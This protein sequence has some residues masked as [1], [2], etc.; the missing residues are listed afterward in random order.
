MAV[1][2]AGSDPDDWRVIQVADVPGGVVSAS[3][4]AAWIERGRQWGGVQHQLALPLP[5]TRYRRRAFVVG[6]PDP[7]TTAEVDLARDLRR[8]I[9]GLDRHRGAFS[10]WAR[11]AG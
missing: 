3:V 9:A 4:T 2:A 10:R 7:F 5:R 6:R 1:D 11:A 8:L